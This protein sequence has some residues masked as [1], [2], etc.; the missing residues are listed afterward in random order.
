MKL[1]SS[2]TGHY[3]VFSLRLEKPVVHESLYLLL[4]D[5]EGWKIHSEAEALKVLRREAFSEASVKLPPISALEVFDLL[6]EHVRGLQNE[7]NLLFAKE[8]S[9]L[10]QY[11]KELHQEIASR[12]QAL[13]YHTYYFDREQQL[14]LEEKK[15]GQEMQEQG[16]LLKIRF[17]PQIE[18]KLLMFGELIQGL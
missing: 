4:H 14:I 3:I 8:L 10:N 11:Y 2:Q 9:Q 15:A 12:K 16:E 1:K 7:V 13:Y 18:L 6:R 5:D 17:S